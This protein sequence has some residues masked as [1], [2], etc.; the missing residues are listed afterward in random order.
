MLLLLWVLYG[1]IR[2]RFECPSR[3]IVCLSRYDSLVAKMNASAAARAIRIRASSPVTSTSMS[4]TSST[5][6]EP[7]PAR[8]RRRFIAV[9][10]GGSRVQCVY[11]RALV[12][13]HQFSAGDKCVWCQW[14]SVPT[15]MFFSIYI[16]SRVFLETVTA[17]ASLHL[18]IYSI[19]LIMLSRI[20]IFYRL[21]HS[22]INE[23][24]HI[25]NIRINMNAK[26]IYPQ[27]AGNTYTIMYQIRHRSSL[28]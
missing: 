7:S 25:S 20:K 17:S 6:N 8:S 23:S 22:H 16:F 26:S 10:F 1:F 11:V 3:P 5:A 27:G 24:S 9:S 4:L 18:F 2:P 19:I 14:F 28:N 21:F 12:C 15:L 13:L